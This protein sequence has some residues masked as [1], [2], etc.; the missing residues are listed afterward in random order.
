PRQNC[1]PLG[2]RIVRGNI[3]SLTGCLAG[4]FDENY[5]LVS[6]ASD[7]D[8]EQLVFL[9]VQ[10]VVL[11]AS[12]SVPK[13]LVV[14]LGDRVFSDIEES[15]V[16]RGP[17]DAVNALDLLGQNLAGAKIL[18]LQNVLPINRVVGGERQQCAVFAGQ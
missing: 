5:R 17:D 13:Q 3:T 18:D 14:A 1:F 11:V 7:T 4:R 12:Q 9:L 6:G 10:Q 15:F 2:V 8:I 16:V